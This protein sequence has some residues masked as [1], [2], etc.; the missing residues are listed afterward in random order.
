M[1]LATAKLER[2]ITF[3]RKLVMYALYRFIFVIRMYLS[4]EIHVSIRNEKYAN[5][6]TEYAQA[7]SK[8]QPWKRFFMEKITINVGKV[9]I[10][11]QKSDMFIIRMN[12]FEIVFNCPVLCSD[13]IKARFEIIVTTESIA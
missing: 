10:P 4:R 13:N 8:E 12:L 9:M 11:K 3:I 6:R 7:F 1:A 2:I 5:K